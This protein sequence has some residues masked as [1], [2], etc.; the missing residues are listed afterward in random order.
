M[1]TG[2]EEDGREERAIFIGTSLS[3][4]KDILQ[5][6]AYICNHIDRQVCIN[7]ALFLSLSLLHKF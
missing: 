1:V 4:A 3:W 5:L 2:N 6:C 7:G